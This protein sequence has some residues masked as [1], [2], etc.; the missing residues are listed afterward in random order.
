MIAP[1]SLAYT[2]AG[3]QGIQKWMTPSPASRESLLGCDFGDS[4]F[5]PAGPPLHPQQ[6]VAVPFNPTQDMYSQPGDLFLK[7]SA[8]LN[9]GLAATAAK[10]TGEIK[11]DF[12]NLGSRM[13]AIENKLDMMVAVTN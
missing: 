7:L 5:S 11:A 4:A 6:G 13:E 10:I 2:P 1:V 12:Q 9:K 3:L 8:L